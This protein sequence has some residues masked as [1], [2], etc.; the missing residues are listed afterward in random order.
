M[1]T[2]MMLI[3]LCVS[4]QTYTSAE[5]VMDFTPSN[6]SGTQWDKSTFRGQLKNASDEGIFINGVSFSRPNESMFLDAGIFLEDGPAYLDP[7]ESWI[8][9]FFDIYHEISIAPGDYIGT[10]FILGGN[11]V[12]DANS[13]TVQ[14]FQVTILPIVDYNGDGLI[15]LQDLDFFASAWL[16]RPCGE[17]NFWCDNRDITHSGYVNLEDFS[18]FALQWLK[19]DTK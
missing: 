17:N 8:G 15:G 10:F 6:M 4:M 14:N 7:N 12:E 9:D 3:L 19:E 1:K 18:I 13:L 5:L 16:S 2:K 11:S